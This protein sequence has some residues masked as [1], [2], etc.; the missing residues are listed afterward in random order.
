VLEMAG[1]PEEV[2]MLQ[3]QPDAKIT[4]PAQGADLHTARSADHA[5]LDG[6][7]VM[8]HWTNKDEWVD[9]QFKVSRPG[10]FDVAIVTSEQKYGKGWDGGHRVTLDVAGKQMKGV[11]SND[12]HL[13]NPSNPYWPYVISKI[14]QVEIGKTGTYRMALKP[15]SIQTPQGFGFTL[16]DVMLS[17]HQ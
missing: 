16:V 7:G 6:R 4:L 12:G 3:Q 8:E 11:V 1:Q 13:E 5:R 9:W 14:G 10:V 17:P 15:E 2:T